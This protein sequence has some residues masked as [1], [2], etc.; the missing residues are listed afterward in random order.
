MDMVWSKEGMNCVLS[1]EFNHLST[2]T[3][4]SLWAL[5]EIYTNMEVAIIAEL[6]ADVVLKTFN[7]QEW[8]NPADHPGNLT[9]GQSFCRMMFYFVI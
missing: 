9:R 6:S 5:V 1:G 7:A 2:H 4:D 3:E 8:N